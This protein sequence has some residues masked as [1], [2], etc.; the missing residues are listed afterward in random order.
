MNEAQTLLYRRSLVL[1]ARRVLLVLVFLFDSFNLRAQSTASDEL[2]LGV[3]DQKQAKYDHAAEHFRRAVSLDPHSLEAHLHLAT[4]YSQQ[5]IPGTDDS[6]DLQIVEAA[7]SEY[8][9]AL[10]IDPNNLNS[11]KGLAYL[12]LQTKRFEIAKEYYRKAIEINGEDPEPYYSTA[13]IDWTQSYQPRMETRAKL[14]LKPDQ[15]LIN[16]PV[17]WELRSNVEDFIEEGITMLVEAVKRRPDYD[18]AMAYMNLLYRERADIQCGDRKAYMADTE[19]A[20]KWVDLT[21]ATKKANWQKQKKEGDGNP[22][23]QKSA[24]N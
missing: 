8:Q 17:C 3:E 7:E 15:P 9:K 12:N 4:T 22:T 21:M 13:V 19:S 23:E 24:P 6:H 2:R 11:V 1:H 5:Y 10:E 16:E 14:R 20:D 18:D